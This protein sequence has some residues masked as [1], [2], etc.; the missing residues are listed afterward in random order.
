MLAFLWIKI[1]SWITV[2]TRL[3]TMNTEGIKR[4]TGYINSYK[5]V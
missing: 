1:K 5:R 2:S 4:Y 3:S